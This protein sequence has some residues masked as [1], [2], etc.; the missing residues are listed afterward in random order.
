MKQD[1]AE[2]LKVAKRYADRDRVP[3]DQILSS[4]S[5]VVFFGSRAAKVNSCS[6]DL[7]I[8]CIGSG[9][10]HKSA[11]LDI[12]W[13]SQHESE[14][15]NWF[16]S[17][18]AGHVGA[19][20]V[21]LIGKGSWCSSIHAGETAARQKERRIKALS[22]GLQTYWQ[23]LHPDF[24]HKYLVMIRREIQ[25]LDILRQGIAI[26][27]TPQLDEYWTSHRA[28]D[29]RLADTISCLGM[30]ELITHKTRLFAILSDLNISRGSLLS[31]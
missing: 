2:L 30:P 27:P 21:W 11:H 15:A 8:L 4:A 17:E 20:G 29:D 23:R 10:R 12:V 25:R 6:S 3:L 14:S 26:P 22:V 18:L 24:Q 19:Y 16:S 1:S 5:E 31:R 28:S 7:D 13:K 9:Q